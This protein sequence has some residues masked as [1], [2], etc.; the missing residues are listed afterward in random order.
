MSFVTQYLLGCVLYYLKNT[1]VPVSFLS[2]GMCGCTSKQCVL[3]TDGSSQKHSRGAQVTRVALHTPLSWKQSWAP[4]PTYPRGEQSCR[5]C[6]SLEGCLV[7]YWF[8]SFFS[9]DSQPSLLASCLALQK[10]SVTKLS[11]WKVL[12]NEENKDSTGKM[13]LYSRGVFWLLI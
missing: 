13:Q 6:F 12:L 11:T 7:W 5:I 4:R 1:V 3:A 10:S 2:A 9:I 8:M